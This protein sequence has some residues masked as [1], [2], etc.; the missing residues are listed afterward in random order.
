MTGTGTTSHTITNH[1][2]KPDPYPS[3]ASVRMPRTNAAATSATGPTKLCVML[4]IP[5]DVPVA[6]T[7]LRRNAKTVLTGTSPVTTGAHVGSVEPGGHG[8]C[9]PVTTSHPTV[10]AATAH[11]T[12]DSRW[13]CYDLVAIPI[14]DVKDSSRNVLT[15]RLL[16]L[17]F[18]LLTRLAVT[19]ANCRTCKTPTARWWKAPV[20]TLFIF[21]YWPACSYVLDHPLALMSIS[22]VCGLI[23]LC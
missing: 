13:Y 1:S 22:L 3:H 6:D 7:K 10:V 19:V 8:M 15:P 16:R 2:A 9:R 14:F 5:K 18:R 23:M 20:P 17:T 21:A 12:P 11:S 4:P